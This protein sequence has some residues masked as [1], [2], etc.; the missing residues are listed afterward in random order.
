MIKISHIKAAAETVD[1]RNAVFWFRCRKQ[2]TT[3][4]IS[5]LHFQHDAEHPINNSS[6][7]KCL[8]GAKQ[9][10]GVTVFQQMVH[11]SAQWK[12]L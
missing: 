11:Y 7:S 9:S 5:I 2:Q 3:D 4:A 12:L 10:C 8:L 6:M 1:P